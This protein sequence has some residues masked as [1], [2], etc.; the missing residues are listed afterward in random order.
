MYERY[1]P[2]FEN[3][4]HKDFEYDESGNE[5]DLRREA[6]VFFDHER[7]DNGRDSDIKTQLAKLRESLS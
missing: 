5:V 6:E 1:Q 7:I 2:H 3:E 4:S